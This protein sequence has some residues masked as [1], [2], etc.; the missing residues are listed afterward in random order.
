VIV[1]AA[2]HTEHKKRHVDKWGDLNIFGENI[3]RLLG[4][5]SSRG[6][7]EKAVERMRLLP[8]FIDEP[9]C[10]FIDEDTVGEIG[11][12]EGFTHG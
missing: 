1:Y 12:V 9:D 4:V 8:G 3:E 7:A 5:Y 2:Y 11:W 10:F 6:A